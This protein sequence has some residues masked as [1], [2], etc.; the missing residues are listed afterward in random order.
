MNITESWLETFFHLTCEIQSNYDENWNTDQITEVKTTQSL[1][2]HTGLF[3]L[4]KQWTN[5]FEAAHKNTNWEETDFYETLEEFFNEKN[6][7]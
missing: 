5:E 4:A 3:D 2:G 7:Q 1:Y 6:K